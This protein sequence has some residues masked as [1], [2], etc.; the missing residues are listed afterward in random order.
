MKIQI[1]TKNNCAVSADI[2]CRPVE[3]LLIM[4]ALKDFA[5]DLSNHP[6]NVKLAV[7]MINTD[8]ELK[9]QGEN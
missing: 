8:F 9:E 6:D 3:F 2:H 4:R 1:N 5:K 7:L